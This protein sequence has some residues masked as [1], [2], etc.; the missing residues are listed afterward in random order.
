MTIPLRQR[1]NATPSKHLD[2]KIFIEFFL[3][4]DVLRY[5][6]VAKAIQLAHSQL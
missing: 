4:P 6:V 5:Y 3:V 2:L 1:D